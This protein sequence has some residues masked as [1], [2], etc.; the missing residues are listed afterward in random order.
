MVNSVQMLL[1]GIV[2]IS[3][4]GSIFGY[5]LEPGRFEKRDAAE[6]AVNL[7]GAETQTGNHSPR[8]AA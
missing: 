6:L 4:I 3:A 1:L 8:L 7:S 5:L 2:I